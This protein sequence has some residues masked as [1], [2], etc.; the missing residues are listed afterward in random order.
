MA[1]PAARV[2]HGNIVRTGEIYAPV[3][4]DTMASEIFIIIVISSFDKGY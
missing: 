3:Q 4:A 2:C 1:C